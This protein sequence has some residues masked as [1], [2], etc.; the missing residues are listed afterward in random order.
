MDQ[1]YHGQAVSGESVEWLNMMVSNLFQLSRDTVPL[2]ESLFSRSLAESAVDVRRGK[3]GRI[4]RESRLEDVRLGH[5]LPH[6]SR[7]GLMK[8]SKGRIPLTW[9]ADLSYSGGLGGILWIKTIW[10]CDVYI[11]GRL[12]RLEGRLMVML[13][14]KSFHL[15]FSRIDSLEI[16]ARVNVAGREWRALNWI[17]S[18]FLL[19]WK[20]K[21]KYL[22]PGMKSKWIVDGP[23]KP[24]YPW[25]P[26]VV[27]NPDLLYQEI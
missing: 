20:F 3:L 7:V 4:V 1:I 19:P 11:M 21:N 26:E 9:V 23:S 18:R 8:D 14:E 27:A 6:L 24:K 2:R 15:T 5:S 25:D 10:D 16:E 12:Q 22:L 17:M 13:D